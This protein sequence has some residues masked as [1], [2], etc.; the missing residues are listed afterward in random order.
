MWLEWKWTSD[1]RRPHIRGEWNRALHTFSLTELMPPGYTSEWHSSNAAGQSIEEVYMTEYKKSYPF[2]KADVIQYHFI[3]PEWVGNEDYEG[4]YWYLDYESEWVH[5]LDD[6][7]LPLPWPESESESESES[8]PDD[9]ND[10]DWIPG[11]N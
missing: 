2:K 10:L 7:D 3:E 9:Q 8:E 4:H 5:Y 1:P 6:L 11:L